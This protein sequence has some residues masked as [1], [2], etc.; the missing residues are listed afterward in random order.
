MKHSK[1]TITLIATLALASGA[2]A[3]APGAASTRGVTLSGDG[4]T[5]AGHA[6]PSTGVAV[7]SAEGLTLTGSIS[8]RPLSA[9]VAL[10]YGVL[11]TQDKAV[12]MSLMGAEDP[13]ADLAEPR[14]VIDAADLSEFV[15]RYET[16]QPEG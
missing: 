8:V 10:P 4:F 16:N 3:T 6:Q 5:L 15:R 11:D 1:R 12:F 9:D 2:L 7:L 13:R 14:G